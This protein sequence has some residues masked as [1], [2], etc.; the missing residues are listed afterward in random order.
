MADRSGAGV[1]GVVFQIEIFASL[2]SARNC[3]KRKYTKQQ[4]HICSDSQAVL[5]ALEAS[6]IMSKLVLECGQAICA[7][8]EMLLQLCC[9]QPELPQLY[10][11]T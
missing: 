7:D 11:T 3:M 4:I 10:F 2:A 9:K 1:C 6:L 8:K 5:R